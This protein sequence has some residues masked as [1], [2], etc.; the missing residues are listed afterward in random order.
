MERDERARFTILIVED[1]S[2]NRDYLIESLAEEGYRVEGAGGGRAGLDRIRGG[3]IDLVVSD[4]RMPDLDGLDMLREIKAQPI[5]PDVI[6]ITAFGSIDTAKKALKLGAY[7]YL[8]KP[9]EIDDL[10]HVIDKPLKVRSLSGEVERL[11]AEVE[12]PYRLDSILGRSAA[13]QEVFDLIRRLGQSAVSVLVTG[14]S[15]TGKELVA[16]A[17]HQG[18]QR[19]GR[20]FV[21]VNCAAIPD[22]LL[23]S[24]LFGYKKGAF[25]DAKA[26]RPGMFLE[27][28]GGTLFFDEIAELS[29]ALQAKLL[30]VVQEHEVRPLGASRSE[31]VDVRIIAA[32]N[33]DL[34][35][36]LRDGT[37]REDLFYRL[38]VIQVALP[39]LRDRG[40]DIMLLAEHFLAAAAERAH[41]PTRS[42]TQAAVEIMLAYPWPGNVRELENVVERAVALSES[43]EIDA[44]DLPPQVRARRAEDLLQAAMARGL[45]LADLEREYIGRVLAAEGGNKTRAAQRLGLDRKTL[46]R[47]LEEYGREKAGVG[48]DGDEDEDGKT[49]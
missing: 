1:D 16:R 15:G 11:R 32:T 24:E 14:E 34:E 26:D 3:G 7:E 19:K 28:D 23:E 20:A 12:R 44:G 22:T 25:T 5:S 9:F 37:F 8:T 39:P 30:R 17:I 49:L 2:A 45:S 29:P 4:I 42:F 40:P 21:A 38:N 33:R 6:M 35:P 46:Y 41:K 36:R 18:S 13:M 43:S 47:K 27:A 10:V 48:A 31:K